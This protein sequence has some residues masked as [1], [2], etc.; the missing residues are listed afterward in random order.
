MTV[1]KS[2]C[3]PRERLTH[4]QAFRFAQAMLFEEALLEWT[5]ASCVA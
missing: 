1:H 5:F 3:E 2:G 4:L